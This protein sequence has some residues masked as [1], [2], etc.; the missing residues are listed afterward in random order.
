VDEALAVS[1]EKRRRRSLAEKCS[2]VEQAMQA[3][4]RVA[5][6]ARRHGINANLIFNWRKLYLAGRLGEVSL[7]SGG[8][9]PVKV[10]EASHVAPA[11]AS[12][13]GTISIQL[14]KARIRIEGRADANT[15]AMVLERLLR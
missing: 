11:L 3:G 14:S 13:S 7:Q 4:V 8:L 9:L 6:I 1:Q 15:L 12:E 10:T 2:I 5:E